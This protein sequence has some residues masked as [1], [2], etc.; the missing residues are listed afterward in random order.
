MKT[1]HNNQEF[2]QFQQ[3]SNEEL[4]TINGGSGFWEDVAYITGRTLRCI[5]EFSKTASE[6]Q[7]S[8][9]ANLKK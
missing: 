7:H 1:N 3:L 9:P 5:W 8:L 4:L 6:Y 2:N